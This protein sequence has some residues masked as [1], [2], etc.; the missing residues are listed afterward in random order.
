MKMASANFE[1]TVVPSRWRN[2]TPLEFSGSVRL[3]DEDYIKM[4]EKLQMML[5]TIDPGQK[6]RGQPSSG[7][8]NRF[9][10]TEGQAE[11]PGLYQEIHPRHTDSEKWI[12]VGNREV[13]LPMKINRLP[14]R[15]KKDDTVQKSKAYEKHRQTILR[16][17]QRKQSRLDELKEK[18]EDFLAED[19]EEFL[20]GMKTAIQAK[21][22][23]IL[24]KRVEAVWEVAKCRGYLK[25]IKD[26]RATQ[27]KTFEKIYLDI[28]EM[29]EDLKKELSPMKNDLEKHAEYKKIMKELDDWTKMIKYSKR[30][31]QVVILHS[32]I[33]E[34]VAVG[35]GKCG[36]ILSVVSSSMENARKILEHISTVWSLAAF[37]PRQM[38]NEYVAEALNRVLADVRKTVKKG[39]EKNSKVYKTELSAVSLMDRDGGFLSIDDGGVSVFIPPHDHFGSNQEIHLSLDTESALDAAM[40]TKLSPLAQIDVSPV[41][42]VGPRGLKLDE[43]AILTIPHC[44]PEPSRW[45]LF[46]KTKEENA[47]GDKKWELANGDNIQ[48]L[49]RAHDAVIFIDRPGSF[50][51]VAEPTVFSGCPIKSMCV[52][53]FFS[54]KQRNQDTDISEFRL[55]VWNDSPATVKIVK[56]LERQQFGGILSHSGH[57]LLYSKG[58]DVTAAITGTSAG[59]DVCDDSRNR[60][61]ALSKIW[62]LSDTS[63]FHQVFRVKNLSGDLRMDDRRAYL[64]VN[65]DKTPLPATPLLLKHAESGNTVSEEMTNIDGKDGNSAEESELETH[66]KISLRR[67]LYQVIPEDVYQKLCDILDTKDDSRR[68]AIPPDWRG[69]AL[70]YNLELLHIIPWVERQFN[71]SPTRVICNFIIGEEFR[72]EK[73]TL[74]IREDLWQL[75]L[76]IQTAEAADIVEG[77]TILRKEDIPDVAAILIEADIADDVKTKLNITEDPDDDNKEEVSDETKEEDDA[78]ES[79]SDID[80]DASPVQKML[81]MWIKQRKSSGE[82]PT[83]TE[84]LEAIAAI[85]EEVK[86]RVER[87]LKII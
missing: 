33:K 3:T 52:G 49:V 7:E 42:C 15:R 51:I 17:V 25:K 45:K 28:F 18:W 48:I 2:D 22:R 70:A 72:E 85:D 59:W 35:K 50:K 81:K 67:E 79:A 62:P 21:R 47:E 38:R 69:L 31:R 14:W 32:Q 19:V 53:T 12:D 58:S 26:K 37:F 27:L 6:Y 77:V 20:S 75:C 11:F 5:S 16:L 73:S 46:V 55:H 34:S 80:E 76:K 66:L 57:I 40:P 36:G 56:Y 84:L 4:G 74:Q 71:I 39:S 43:A 44:L 61:F 8:V 9:F 64:V 68:T 24:G 60:K 82:R 13:A 83:L 87:V 10:L 86:G 1:P 29:R 63:G 30:N 54:P 41:V 23:M 65:Q 78:D